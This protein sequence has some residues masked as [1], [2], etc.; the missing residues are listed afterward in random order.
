MENINNHKPR[1]FQE[2][3]ANTCPECGHNNL[4]L[5]EYECTKSRLN[6]Q[7]FVCDSW[8]DGCQVKLQCANCGKEYYNIEKVG[9]SYRIKSN[10]PPIKKVMTNFNPFLS[11]GDI[12]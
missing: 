3:Y 10:L 1:L 9:M 6:D 8:T 12:I 2:V 4:W 5:V 7:G 11:E